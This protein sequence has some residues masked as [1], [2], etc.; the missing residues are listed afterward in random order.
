M[1]NTIKIVSW[2]KNM[3]RKS[4][5]SFE[6]LKI[7]SGFVLYQTQIKFMTTDPV[8]FKSPGLKDRAYVYVDTVRVDIKILKPICMRSSCK[9]MFFVNL[10]FLR[11]L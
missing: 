10:S 5:L 2:L 1:K 9:F 8:L 3:Y 11:I 4:A 6:E 7:G